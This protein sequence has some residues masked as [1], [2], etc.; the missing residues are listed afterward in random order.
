M[1][2]LQCGAMPVTMI[3]C[4]NN[5]HGVDTSDYLEYANIKRKPLT[6]LKIQNLKRKAQT[7]KKS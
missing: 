1:Y 2:P 3:D 4:F 6:T 7:T 5:F